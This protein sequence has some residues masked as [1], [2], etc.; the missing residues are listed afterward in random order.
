MKESVLLLIS[1]ESK[2]KLNSKKYQGN[3][4]PTRKKQ[5]ETAVSGES[6]L[7]RV[8]Y[9]NINSYVV[10]IV[11]EN[12][13]RR[14]I[15]LNNPKPRDDFEAVMLVRQIKQHLAEGFGLCACQ[16]TVNEIVDGEILPFLRERSDDRKNDRYCRDLSSRYNL[17]WRK[18][19]EG[20]KPAN[21]T[22]QRLQRIADQISPARAGKEKLSAATYNRALAAISAIGKFLESRGYTSTNPARGLQRRKENN[23]RIRVVRD[24]EL[25]RLFTVLDE[26]P[27]L[28]KCYVQI[29]FRTM[30]RQMELL[31]AT[32]VDVSFEQRTLTLHDTKN[33]QPHVLPLSDGAIDVLHRLAALRI[34]NFL[35]PGK[36]AAG[37]MGRPGR[38]LKALFAKA[39][40]PDLWAHDFRRSG[41][42]WACRKGATV[43]D[44]SVVL[45]HGSVAVTQR[46]IV[47]HN[48]R[49]HSAVE[50][51]DEFINAVL[52]KKKEE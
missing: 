44:V 49:L 39:A 5:V 30:A 28:F 31:R 8:E 27:E 10:S 7:T 14:R 51:V 4:T 37:H 43:H 19:L 35:F 20:L 11:D 38:Q 45:N 23:R 41:A 33:G 17:Y 13:R 9:A 48:P 22:R 2:V 16:R 26:F 12:G 42:T 32:W 18:A 47:A 52:T 3:K 1:T 50:G 25:S 6:G 21:L 29:S 24:D 34:N 15:T 36:T 40:V 46:Y